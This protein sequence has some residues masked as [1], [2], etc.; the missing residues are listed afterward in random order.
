MSTAWR[1]GKGNWLV[2]GSHVSTTSDINKASIIS[3]LPKSARNMGFKKV[4]VTVI[5]T[6]KE[7]T[8]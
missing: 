2:L 5:R 8:K 6:I 4:E 7:V 3:Y 1:N